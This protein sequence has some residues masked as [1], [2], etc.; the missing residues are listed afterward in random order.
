MIVAF[1]FFS[2]F[3]FGA[4]AMATYSKVATKF[5]IRRR[6]Q[7]TA[8]IT[9]RPEMKSQP[10]YASHSA[11]FIHRTDQPSIRESMT[12]VEQTAYSGPFHVAYTDTNSEQNSGVKVSVDRAEDIV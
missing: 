1:I 9:S 5:G 8:V 7:S 11:P 12:N 4:E 6:S 10:R 3:G 2:A